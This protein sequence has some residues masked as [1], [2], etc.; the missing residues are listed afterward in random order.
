MSVRE[1]IID[2]LTASRYVKW[3]EARHIEQR[4][5]YT[6][7]LADKDTQ[8]K[9]LR[10][11]LAT[12]KLECDR[13]RAVL[14]PFGSPSGAAYAQTFQDSKPPMVPAFDGPDDWQAELSK[15]YEKEQD[16]GIPSERREAVHESSADDG[17]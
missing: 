1:I 7:R 6:A 3:L 4:Q 8:I 10:I 15:M 17:A 5:D 13:M 11:E 12:A 14:M 2:W 16:N 9:Q